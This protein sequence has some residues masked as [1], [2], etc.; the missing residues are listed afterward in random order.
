[1]IETAVDDCPTAWLDGCAAL[2][3]EWMAVLGLDATNPEVLRAYLLGVGLSN[4]SLD[5][6][7]GLYARLT[8]LD[9]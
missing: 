9:V 4:P 6:V 5:L 1:M 8:R 2:A 7:M 3:R